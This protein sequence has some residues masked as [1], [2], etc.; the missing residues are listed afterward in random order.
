MAYAAYCESFNALNNTFVDAPVARPKKLMVLDI[1][2]P[3]CDAFKVRRLLAS[4]PQTGVLR[5]IP[6]L[7]DRTV[8][9][10]IQ[11]SAE[12]VQ[13]VMHVLMT[14]VPS[15]EMGTLNSWSH[16]LSSRGMT[17]GL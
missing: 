8:V 16:H 6:K 14:C 9:L 10:E 2:V 7:R 13:E 5:C 12:R 17:H 15:G 1:T 3:S 4:C 11:L